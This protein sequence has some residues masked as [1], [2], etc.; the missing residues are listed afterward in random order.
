MTDYK[1]LLFDKS[2]VDGEWVAEFEEKLD[3]K[4]P[5]D[6]SS[7]GS[8]YNSGT[9][10][11]QNAIE[12]AHR[13][14]VP[15]REKTA[16]ERQAVLEK[17]FS[18]IIENKEAIATIMTLECGKP[19]TES[20]G[21]VDYGASFIQWF[22]EEAK[23][24][25]GDVIPGFSADRRVVVIRQPIGVV[26]ALTPW[27][28]PLAMITRKVAPALAVGCPVV[29]RPSE[30]TPFTALALA[31]LAQEAGFPAG[32]FNLIVSDEP[33]AIG[34]FL[35]ESELVSKISFTGSTRVGQLLSAQS[36]STLK[37]LS[38]E[39]GGNAPFLVF[40]DADID[41]AVKGAIASKFRNA[42]QTCVCVNR[43]L[44]Q[45]SVYDEF[46]RK[47]TEAVSQLKVGNGL[48]EG[49]QIGPLINKKAI[50]KTKSFVEDAKEKGGKIIL[51][52]EP[53]DDYFFQPTV[54]SE[55]TTD[56]KFAKEEI[57]G[58]IAPIFRFHTDEE[59]VQMANDTIF[60]LASYIY[61]GSVTRSW[62]ISEALEYGMV[63]INEGIISTE[64][65][66]FGG[67]K[68]SGK[69]REGSKYGIDDYTELKYL[70]FGGV[71]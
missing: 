54:I 37:T 33:A 68:Y 48:D 11:L 7:I 70:C 18:L 34:E 61:T 38:L 24:V 63:G 64:V 36:A 10:L 13:A 53:I 51:G 26:G 41:A 50:D 55:A 6:G 30:E 20:R 3:V 4:N 39:L 59:G 25:Y 40:D 23:R 65:A 46:T 5:A 67:V 1:N 16:K 29:I 60:G 43:F 22:A 17:W 56:M 71:K 28:F 27:N 15:W 52:G 57:F 66:P 31:K 35:C 69:G 58:P 47:F 45:D 44:V 49:V 12:A 42:G 21:E 8:I 19:L 32:V 14:F 62:K 9:G 2:F